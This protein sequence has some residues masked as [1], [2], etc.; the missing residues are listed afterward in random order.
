MATELNFICSLQALSPSAPTPLFWLI[1]IYP[2]LSL[3]TCLVCFVSQK[4]KAVGNGCAGQIDGTALLL[5]PSFPMSCVLSFHFS[6]IIYEKLVCLVFFFSKS[7][8]PGAL[9]EDPAPTASMVSVFVLL[10]SLVVHAGYTQVMVIP[11]TW[12]AAGSFSCR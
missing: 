1:I 12:T 7:E 4:M 6:A 10:W 9:C 3:T 2:L 5:F 8:M 11:V